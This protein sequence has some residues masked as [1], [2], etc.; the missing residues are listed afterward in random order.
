[1]STAVPLCQELGFNVPAH[2]DEASQK[3]VVDCAF[4]ATFDEKKKRWLLEDGPTTWDE[5]MKR[6][7]TARPQERR[8]RRAGA[9]RQQGAGAA[10]RRGGRVMSALAWAGRAVSARRALGRSTRGARPGDGHLAR[11]YGPDRGST[12]GRRRGVRDADLHGD[13]LPRHEHD[14]GRHPRAAAA[15]CL[16]YARSRSRRSGSRSGRRRG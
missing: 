10:A 6:W 7:K 9:A 4:P 13:G 1:M 8:V 15:R 14:R 2:F 5:V 3:W 12:P 11:G 16:A